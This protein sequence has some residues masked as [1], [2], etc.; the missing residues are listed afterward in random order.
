MRTTLL[1]LSAIVIVILLLILWFN[2]GESERELQEQR[3]HFE[4][5]LQHHIN[6]QTRLKMEIR[7][8]EH[9]D[10]A[11]KRKD[12]ISAET[13]RQENELIRAQLRQARTERVE[14]LIEEE[15]ELKL[16]VEY[17]DSLTAHQSMRIDTLEIQRSVQEQMYN[18]IT[19]KKDELIEAKELENEFLRAEIDKLYDQLRKEKRKTK[20]AKI[21]AAIFLLLNAVPRSGY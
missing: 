1:V 15:P 16:F 14:Q 4:D 7:A 19:A 12:S 17:Y 8:E 3:K 9:R 11:R 2:R 6:V 5:S 20:R 10:R 18:I 21:L 13:Y